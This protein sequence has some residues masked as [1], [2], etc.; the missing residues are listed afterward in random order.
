MT[1]GKVFDNYSG[2]HKYDKYNSQIRFDW[3]FIFRITFWSDD[4]K[5]LASGMSLSF[6][7]HAKNE[8]EAKMIKDFAGANNLRLAEIGESDDWS[9]FEVKH[10]LWSTTQYQQIPSSFICVFLGW[11]R[12]WLPV[13]YQKGSTI[14]G[15]F[16]AKYLKILQHW[17]CSG[18]IDFKGSE[19]SRCS[20]TWKNE[21]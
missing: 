12:L 6:T 17:L 3:I 16:K 9:K 8:D 11:R 13:I 4:Q 20:Q 14:F 2:I 19:W 10:F 5:Y 15:F 1:F 18:K 7:I 21:L